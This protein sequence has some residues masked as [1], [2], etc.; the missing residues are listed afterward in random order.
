[1]AT[2]HIRSASRI[3]LRKRK[4]KR[5]AMVTNGDQMSTT[6]LDGYP[7]DISSV[8]HIGSNDSWYWVCECGARGKPKGM[9][10][11]MKD[12]DKHESKC[13]DDTA[14]RATRKVGF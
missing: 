4:R 12:G 11:S 3:T 6:K 10:E 9:G 1:M 8:T 13:A 5:G 2:R 7:F 14:K